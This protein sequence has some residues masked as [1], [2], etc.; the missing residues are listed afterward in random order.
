MKLARSAKVGV[1]ILA[2]NDVLLSGHEAA[3]SLWNFARYCAIGH[4]WK[5][6]RWRGHWPW[7][8]YKDR[9]PR[10]PGKFGM[11][12][13]LRGT[14]EA[15]ALSDRCFT[16]TIGELD[17]AIRSFFVSLRSNPKARPPRYAKEPRGL[18]FEIGRNAKP[19]DNWTYRLTVL[20]GSVSNRHALIQ[21]QVQ[22]GIKMKQV[23]LIRVQP[24]GTGTIVYYIQKQ[25]LSGTQAAAV[26]LG[27]INLAALTFQDGFSILYN[28][29]GLLSRMQWYEKRAAKCK[30]SGWSG[31]GHQRSKQSKR[32]KS[33]RR[34]AGDIRKLAVH[35]LTRDIIDECVERKAGVLIVGD[36]T[37]IRR[38][39]NFGKAG[40]QKLH[41]WPF[42]EIRR[43]LEYK[44]EEMGIETA[45]ISEA[46]TSK[47]CHFCG[48]IG[49]RVKRGRFVCRDCGVSVN[50]DLNGAA[51]IL[52]KYLLTR[53][54]F[55]VEAIL[56]GLPS[57]SELAVGIGADAQATAKEAQRLVAIDPVIVAK[58]N[59]RNWSVVQTGCNGD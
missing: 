14:E 51:N 41:A 35:N 10:Y 54:G 48:V 11:D 32:L 49:S 25:K 55:E 42:A 26:D 3:R 17:V 31:K 29:R 33:Y 4:N 2:G 37:G 47:T 53:D 19:V 45:A 40:N 15:R 12:K 28:G 46:Y 30:P 20:G 43:Q 1:E 16:N 36:L 59:L 13:A 34:K 8:V 44:A 27:I 38:G 22:P 6:R 21:L 24:D 50:A 18:T 56:P 58:F 52:K 5:V 9:M 23:K 39:K 57:P 7:S